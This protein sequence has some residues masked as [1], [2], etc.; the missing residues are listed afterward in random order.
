MDITPFVQVGLKGENL[1]LH[2]LQ[3]VSS[4]EWAQGSLFERK[5][6][7]LTWYKVTIREVTLHLYSPRKKI[8]RLLTV[9]WVHCQAYFDAPPGKD[10]LALDM[11]SMKKGQVWVNGQSIG[12]Y[13]PANI[14][15]GDC[16][17]CR[18]T[19]AFRQQKCQSGCGLP[20]QRW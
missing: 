11:G 1:N 14:A 10:P 7:P 15:Q 19:G 16:G 9:D 12:R 3:G 2:S 4:V 18:Y 13:W 17:E 5:N 8:Y 6:Q 20:T